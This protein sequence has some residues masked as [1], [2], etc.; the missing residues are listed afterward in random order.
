MKKYKKFSGL[1]D[2]NEIVDVIDCQT[3]LK[4]EKLRRLL[5]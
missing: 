5:I 1:F 3:I 4:E 2:A